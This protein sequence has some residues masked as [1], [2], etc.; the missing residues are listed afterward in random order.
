MHA[1]MW[2]CVKFSVI[3][4]FYYRQKHSSHSHSY[5]RTPSSYTC[6]ST[7]F[8]VS[9]DVS[10][11]KCALACLWIYCVEVG[12]AVLRAWRH[13]FAHCN[14]RKIY[15]WIRGP[16]DC[17]SS[18][19]R[20]AAIYFTQFALK[21]HFYL[22]PLWKTLIHSQKTTAHRHTHTYKHTYWWPEINV[23]LSDSDG[24]IMYAQIVWVCVCVWTR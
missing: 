23:E 19:F 4:F 13:S 22:T 8:F 18:I 15:I 14:C 5:I 21:P 12:Y 20:N 24:W 3:I 17:K 6:K 9:V 10:T 7:Y 11:N 1:Y 16:M 2:R